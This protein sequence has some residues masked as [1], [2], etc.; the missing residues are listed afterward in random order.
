MKG[1]RAFTMAEVM[2]LT[3]NAANSYTATFAEKSGS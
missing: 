2:T 3:S 1:N